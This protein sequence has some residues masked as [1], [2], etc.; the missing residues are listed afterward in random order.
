VTVLQNEPRI[1]WFDFQYNNSGTWVSRKDAQ[2][3]VDPSQPYEYRFIM[4]ISCDNGWDNIT[5][6]N[7][8]AWTDLGDETNDY[9][10]SKGGNKNLF[11][12]YENVSGA[13][14]FNLI[15]PDDE[16][17]KVDA[18]CTEAYGVDPDGASGYTQNM[19]ITLAF[20]PSYQFRYAPDPTSTGDVYNDLWSWNFNITADTDGGYLSWDNPT[21]GDSIGEFGVFSYTEIVSVGWPTALG[22]PGT[23]IFTNGT[24]GSGNITMVTRANGNYSLAV[25]IDNLTHKTA[26][27]N[28]IQNTSILVAGGNL[29][30]NN[31]SGF[32]SQYFYGGASSYTFA[33]NHTTSMT[34]DPIQ[35]A[36][37]LALGTYPGEYNAT[38]YYHL[39]TQTF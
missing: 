31:F 34:T 28:I 22:V 3:D 24:G 38:I 16:V 1:L 10:D 17:S 21:H 11:L 15:W 6:I 37:D 18:D 30:L 8:T 12:Q 2:I 9:N 14:S 20:I 39:Q 19:N 36:V 5:Y 23:R 35:W 29:S 25:N 27:A 13:E 7:V 33:R 26:P 4:N 32:S